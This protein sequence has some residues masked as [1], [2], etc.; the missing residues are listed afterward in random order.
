MMFVTSY[1]AFVGLLMVCVYLN[2]QFFAE[3]LFSLEYIMPHH[4]IVPMCTNNSKRKVPGLSFY[5]L[6]LNDERLLKK[7]LANMRRTNT[8]ITSSRVCSD[9]F[10]GK[11]RLG[12]N[13]VPTVFAWTKSPP[14]Q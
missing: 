7:W 6:P 11:N 10:A 8:P 13:D 12:K 3:W 14:P 5:C 9:H 2:Y 4:C 1:Y